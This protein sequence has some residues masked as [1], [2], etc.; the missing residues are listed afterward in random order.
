MEQRPSREA[1]RFSAS[2]EIPHILR[3]PK[4]HYRIYRCL[5]TLP[6]LSQI[7]PVHCPQHPISWISVL[8]LSYHLCRG[9]SNF[10]TKTLYT[11]LLSPIRA[12]SPAH[13][14]LLDFISRKTWGEDYRSLSSSLCS[15][16]HSH[17]T[18]SLLCPNI[19]LNTLFSD[20][21]NLRSSLN[22]TD[23]VSHPYTT[24]GQNYNS[25]YLK[26]YI[27]G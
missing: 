3:N 16:L 18:S 17:F 21:L 20:T 19:L 14:I 2:Q 22:V 27:F 12:I 1:N 9:L 13:I 5:P 26:L 4:V 25:V 10:P 8:I 23:Q 6:I 24:T 11:S 7:N 15:F